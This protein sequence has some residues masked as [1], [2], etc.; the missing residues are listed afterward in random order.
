MRRRLGAWARALRAELGTLA[1]A[2]RHPDVPWHAKAIAVCVVAYAVSPIDLV[3]DFIP[4]VGYL[5]DLVL[6]PLGILLAR[7]LVPG[8]VLA[9][10]RAEAVRRAELPRSRAG[11]AIVVLGWAVLGACG[12]F[13]W[14]SLD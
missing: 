1:V 14:R 12:W 13:A 8:D 5:D 11:I 3:P 4:V 10:C 2:A 7:R 9:A 6:L